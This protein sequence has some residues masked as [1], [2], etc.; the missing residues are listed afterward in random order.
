MRE[1]MLIVLTQA[2]SNTGIGISSELPWSSGPE[3]L[4]MKNMKRVYVDAEESINTPLIQVL[5][6]SPDIM[7]RE[8]RIQC[9]LAVDAKNQPSGLSSAITAMKNA[10][11]TAM[12]TNTFDRYFDYTKEYQGD[13][14][15]YT[16]EY[17]FIKVE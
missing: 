9:F 6:S 15:V 17:R 7:S 12:I 1:T 8:T 4:Y 3:P 11:D 2:L 10:R 16:F 13:V 14:L 5:G